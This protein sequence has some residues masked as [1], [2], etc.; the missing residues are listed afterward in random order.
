MGGYLS[1]NVSEILVYNRVLS[2]SD[3][4]LTEVYLADKYG[5]YHPDATWPSAY[6][7]AVQ[8]EIALHQWNRAQADD[9]V[10][11]QANNTELPTNG[12]SLWLRADEGVITSSGNVTALADQTGN[13]TLSQ[14]T[15]TNQPTYVAS[16]VNG[17]PAL[18]FNGNQW[19]ASPGTLAPGLNQD[20]TIITV[21]MTTNPSAGA[22]SLYLGQNNGTS[23]I[24]RAAGYDGS[25]IFDTADSEALG[26]L[27]PTA[28]TFVAE[29]A[30][31]DSTLTSVTFYQNGVQT[32]TG[33]LSGVQ[34]LSAGITL[35]AAGGGGNGWQGDIAEVLVYDHKL[36]STELQQIGV[37]LTNKYGLYANTAPVITPA[38]GSYSSA[39]T[40]AI[41]SGLTIGTIHYTMDGTEP[42]SSSAT[43]TG[44]FSLSGSALV[45]A[46]VF[47]NGNLASPIASSQF[48]INDPDE[49]GLSAAPTSLTVSAASSS[50]IDLG[51]G[52]S[53]LLNYSQVYIYRST[54]GGSYQL[55]AVL[56]S[57][58]S[59]FA[60]TNVTAGNSY[61]YKVGT[62]NQ[63]GVAS[64]TAS[65]SVSPTAA[66][67]LTITVTN[68][69]GAVSLP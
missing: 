57:G 47:I 31:L 12:L 69:T 50:E 13:Y 43:Y 34:N 67:T 15:S 68:P 44:S 30:T 17:L 8:A 51:W 20:M 3:Q 1:G 14:T 19:L 62:L 52:L 11:L 18:R 28:G 61:A 66:S 39:Q 45:S 22:Y 48:Y 23:Y 42:T 38:A 58:E 5:L 24:N 55:I 29:T 49:T 25:E 37:Y 16:D 41:S 63:A 60:D 40:I 10:A 59:S 21:G 64:T 32:D 54:N 46:A 26:G 27:D 56:G 65:S 53:S 35:G 36:S 4:E 2:N 7:S 33:T 6:S 9:Y